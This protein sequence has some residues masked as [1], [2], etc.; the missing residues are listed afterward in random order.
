MKYCIY[1]QKLG[2]YG[3]TA[4]EVQ[5]YEKQYDIYE[6]IRRISS[7]LLCCVVKASIVNIFMDYRLSERLLSIISIV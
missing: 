5:Y 6:N 3:K 4:K 2:F 1:R 7:K